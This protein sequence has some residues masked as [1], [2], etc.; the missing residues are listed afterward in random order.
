MH[1]RVM[2]FSLRPLRPLREAL[3]LYALALLLLLPLSAVSATG[4]FSN[5]AGITI[6]DSTNPPTIATP[7][8]SS[9]IVT[10]LAGQVIAKVTVQLTDFSH[11]FPDDVDIVLVGPQGQNS[12]VLANIGGGSPGASNVTLVLD[13]DAASGLPLTGPLVSGTFKPTR[14]LADFDFSFPA[15]AP[16]VPGPA[17]LSVVNG[18]D[19]NGTWNLFIV[20][21]ANP[22]SG[23]ISGGWSL[24]LTTTP[25]FLSI[26]QAGPDVVLSWSGA[27]TNFTLQ[28]TPNLSEP[29]TWT[30]ATP[31][32]V[33]VSGRFMVTNSAA[34]P[35]RF[36]R[37]IK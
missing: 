8:P 9:I 31:D 34:E 1:P 16:A 32:P 20:D 26:E 33:L 21:D 36:Y 2:L 24:T 30:N 23:S 10:G 15:P 28:T 5:P 19:P 12:V 3:C 25:A 7:Y 14:R 22:D 29:I 18:S 11:T 6:N 27:A 17:A 37:L 4:T 35:T 13:D